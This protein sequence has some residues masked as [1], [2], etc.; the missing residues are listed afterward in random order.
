VKAAA[1]AIC[2][3]YARRHRHQRDEE[4]IR[5]GDAQHLHR[6]TVFMRL[7]EEAGR[8]DH[9]QYRGDNY[10]GERDDEKNHAEHAGHV[11]H[12]SPRLLGRVFGLVFG[13]HRDEALGKGALAENTAQ[14]IGDAEGDVEG[15]GRHAGAGADKAGE[16]DIA[17]ETGDPRQQGHAAGDGRGFKE[18]AAHGRSGV[19]AETLR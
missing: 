11:I 13:E 4:N 7:I 16:Q 6:Q 17:D 5:E 8:Q 18:L 19:V 1:P 14:E 2:I 9:H 12:E 10:A 15:V 3:K